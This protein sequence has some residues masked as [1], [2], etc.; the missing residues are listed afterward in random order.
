MIPGTHAMDKPVERPKGLSRLQLVLLAV[1]GVLVLAI[2]VSIPAMLRWSRAER[3]VNAA[4]LNFGVIKRGDLDR[5]VSGQGRIV[6]ALHPTLFAPVA[7]IVTLQVKA[8]TA[9]KKGQ[10]LARI[11]SPELVSRRVQERSTLQ[12]LQSDL[13]RQEIAARQAA[14]R[15]KQTSDVLAMRLAAAERAMTRAQELSQQG[16]LNRVDFERAKDDLELARLEAENAKQTAQFE[17]ES[18]GFEVEN[19]RLQVARQQSVVLETERQVKQLEIAAPFDGMVANVDVQDRDAIAANAPVMTVVNLSQF[20]VEFDVAENYA[21][22]LLPGTAAEIQYE[23]KPY[24]GKVAA[25]SPEIRDSQVRGTVVFDGQ[26]PAGLR[27]SQRV[28]VRLL[29]ERKSNVLKAPRGP[30]VEAGGGRTAYVIEDGIAT[31]R[32]IQVGSMSVS[33]VEIVRGLSEGD[34][35]VVSDTSQFEGARTVLIRY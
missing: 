1:G 6:A 4:R 25:V 9:V 30:F 16:L 3:A 12:A 23:G 8:G 17:R 5:D 21:S 26:T 35:I 20:E 28:S 11:D 13:G 18:L 14:Q 32:E 15:A 7:G 34:Q 10:L 22:D 19:R 2:A 29:L 27:Q 31:K 33:E 24:P